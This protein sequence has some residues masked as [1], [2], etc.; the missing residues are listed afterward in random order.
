MS[1]WHAIVVSSNPFNSVN[2]HSLRQLVWCCHCKECALAKLHGLLITTMASPNDIHSSRDLAE[3]R[4]F[5]PWHC[6]TKWARQNKL[7]NQNCWS[8]YHFSQEKIHHPLVSDII[9]SYYGKYAIPFLLSRPV[10]VLCPF[11]LSI[12]VNWRNIASNWYICNKEQWKIECMKRD[13]FAKGIWF[14]ISL[15][16]TTDKLI[17]GSQNVPV[18]NGRHFGEINYEQIGQTSLTSEELRI[19]PNGSKCA[20]SR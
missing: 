16:W 3:R 5:L 14:A 15:N 17:I 18:A 2:A 19:F 11:T 7:L 10:Y 9:S 13:L 8:W 12:L 4:H 20:S 6:L 1:F